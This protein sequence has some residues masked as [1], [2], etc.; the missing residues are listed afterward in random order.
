MLTNLSISNILS[1]NIFK[2][3]YVW[4]KIVIFLKTAVNP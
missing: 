2:V 4:I 1:P 3:N